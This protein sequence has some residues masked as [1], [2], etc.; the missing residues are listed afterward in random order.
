[1]ISS[2]NK[3]GLLT[4]EEVFENRVFIIPSYQRGYSWGKTQRADLL[5][6][7]ENARSQDFKHFTGTL[8]AA[9]NGNSDELEIVDGQQRLT[10]LLLLINVIIRNAPDISDDRKQRLKEIFNY[11]KQSDGLQRVF[12]LGIGVDE[13]YEKEI[14]QSVSEYSLSDSKNKSWYNILQARD[15]FQRWVLKRYKSG[16]LEVIL[17]QLGFLLFIPQKS[18]TVGVMFEVIN[19]R[20]KQLSE[21]EKIKNYLI[22]YSI[23]HKE[24]ALQEKIKSTWQVILE[25]LMK[26]EHTT[27]E[28]ENAF[29][30]YCWILFETT[31]KNKSHRVYEGMKVIFRIDDEAKSSAK[32][33]DFLDLLRDASNA[34]L[35]FTDSKNSRIEQLKYHNTHASIMPLFLSIMI[36]HKY[37]GIPVDTTLAYLEKMNFR[38]YV[39]P[40]ITA[41]SNKGQGDLFF[42][43][44]KYF[45]E[46]YPYTDRVPDRWF[47]P[48]YINTFG[49]LKHIAD[50]E[51]AI[52]IFTESL[53]PKSK[54]VEALTLDLDEDY[55]YYSWPGLKY[56]LATYEIDLN[57]HRNLG[58]A[59]LMRS[60]EDGFKADDLTHREHLWAKEH[61]TPGYDDQWA[62]HEK[63]RLGNYALLE[64]GINSS[65]Q[66]DDI[67]EKL[68]LY[69]N[70]ARS[71]NLQMVKDLLDEFNDAK[72]IFENDNVP[73][74]IAERKPALYSRFIDIR[75]AKLVNWALD[76]WKL[77]FDDDNYVVINSFQGKQIR[78]KGFIS[79]THDNKV[80]RLVH[81]E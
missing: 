63:K 51:A 62:L 78:H 58:Y 60:A 57:I 15:D 73:F 70:P 30:R 37:N 33:S 31:D 43:A 81:E 25:N 72:A 80:Y 28:Q 7:I 14:L 1:M 47:Y 50:V 61:R 6:D 65:G 45:F 24:Y 59:E 13:V 77:P 17:E 75:E 71:S 56:L 27:N 21:L 52:L 36:I 23:R 22:Y 54:M 39:L 10:S 9:Q 38:V 12:T 18:D 5:S 67:E 4:L 74:L 46:N 8:V 16:D 41:K 42:I 40:Q 55:D 76:K 66:N 48:N 19:N 79:G 11:R 2:K 44:H 34:L 26:C 64:G 53:C 3:Q 20:G 32:I 68:K 69:F 29:L 49:D 35:I